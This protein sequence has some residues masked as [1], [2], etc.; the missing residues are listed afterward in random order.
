MGWGDAERTRPMDTENIGAR[1]A[2]KIEIR[3]PFLQSLLGFLDRQI[4]FLT[5]TVV[6]GRIYY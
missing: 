4:L 1:R 5:Y 3:S 2:Q 6:Q